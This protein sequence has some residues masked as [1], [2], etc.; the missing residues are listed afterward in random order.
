MT[1][2]SHT[3]KLAQLVEHVCNDDESKA[4]ELFHEIVVEM[5]RDI[6]TEMMSCEDGLQED[7]LEGDME[8]DLAHDLEDV[9][10]GHEAGHLEADA[11]ED[12]ASDML[13]DE[14]ME[15]DGDEEHSHEEHGEEGLEDELHSHEEHDKGT[16]E[17]VDELEDHLMDVDEELAKLQ[18][19]FDEM[20]GEHDH[21][22]VEEG[23]EM[24]KVTVKMGGEQGGGHFAGTEQQENS[25]F[26]SVNST[27][28]KVKLGGEPLEI[29]LGKDHTDFKRQEPTVKPKDL[30][31]TVN[32]VSST[33]TALKPEGKMSGKYLV[34]AKGEIGSG[35]SGIPVEG[36]VDSTIGSKK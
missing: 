2:K 31:K 23:V 13:G 21:T 8:A 30:P 9:H 1:D 35:K 28:E 17:K 16:E 14:D 24:S 20:N 5:A 10:H 26:K 27:N 11:E 33:K 7:E 22:H 6:H 29:G 15:M 34:N 4:S 3:E 18:A 25:P 12:L 32:T 36:N 19:M